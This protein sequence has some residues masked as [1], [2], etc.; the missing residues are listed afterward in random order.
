MP[1]IVWKSLCLIALLGFFLW[2][3]VISSLRVA[4]DVVT[5]RAY[6]APGIVAVPLDAKTDGEIALVANLITLTPGS[7]SIDVSPDRST[8]YVHSM[9]AED[10]EALRESIKSG[11]ERRVLELLR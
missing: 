2:E 7:L 9:F 3:L 1:V 4:W 6:R 8:L 11:F 5:P 10:P